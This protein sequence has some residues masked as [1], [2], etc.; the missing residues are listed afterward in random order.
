LLD[1][2][3]YVRLAVVAQDVRMFDLRIRMSWPRE[4][5]LARDRE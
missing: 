3:P 2:D 5:R 4:D 1:V